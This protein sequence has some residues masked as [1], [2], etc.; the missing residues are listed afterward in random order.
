MSSA[1]EMATLD[2]FCGAGVDAELDQLI[3]A[4]THINRQKPK[5]LVD[6]M[7]WWRRAKGDEV[8]KAKESRNAGLTAPIS[9]QR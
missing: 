5:P 1:P 9:R 6:T 8:L 7:M 2:R 3:S 4:L